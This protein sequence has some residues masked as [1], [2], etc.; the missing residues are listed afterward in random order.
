M[1]TAQSLSGTHPY[2]PQCVTRSIVEE[3]MLDGI[4]ASERADEIA[5]EITERIHREVCPRCRGPLY[6]FE[7][8]MGA[9]SRVTPCRCVVICGRC[10]ADEFN[11][12]ILR[13][14]LSQF[15]RWPV[16]KSDITKRANRAAK[17]MGPATAGIVTASGDAPV[18]VTEDGATELKPRPM[19]GGWAE[20]GYDDEDQ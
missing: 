4:D 6:G 18:I 10:G 11:Q 14:G 5:A 9:G 17:L 7:A 8:D 19:S 20:F 13:T 12:A 15:W 1:S 16:R 2:E 3:W